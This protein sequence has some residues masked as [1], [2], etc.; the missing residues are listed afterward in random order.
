[1]ELWKFGGNELKIHIL[2]LFN[3]I[4]DKIQMPQE[5]ERRMVINRHKKNKKQIMKITEKLRN[6]P[7]PTNYLLT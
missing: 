1:M 3:T 6:C 5:W 2:E 4:V 7:Q